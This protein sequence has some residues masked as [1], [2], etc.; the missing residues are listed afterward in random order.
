MNND[1]FK[2]AMP[3]DEMLEISRK[4]SERTLKE[5]KK[6]RRSEWISNNIVAIL[7]IIATVVIALL[8]LD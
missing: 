3:S 5:E 7:G 6:R 4:I 8:K 2:I 1:D